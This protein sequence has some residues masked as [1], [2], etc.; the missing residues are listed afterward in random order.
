MLAITSIHTT[1]TKA[2]TAPT[3]HVVVK[4]DTLWDLAVKFYGNG[5]AWK[6]ISS[7]NGKPNPKKLAIGEALEI[8]AK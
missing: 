7:A 4:G 2:A 6:T 5:E 3:S 8:P 1:P